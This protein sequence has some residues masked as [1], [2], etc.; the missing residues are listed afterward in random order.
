[1]LYGLRMP[2]P[3]PIGA[4]S[5]ITAAAPASSS[6][7][8]M[9]RVVVGVGQHVNPSRASVRVASS[10]PSMSGN[11]V[12]ESPMTSSLTRSPSPASRAR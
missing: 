5:G 6:C 3:E 8:A 4:P 1:M 10:R 12:R 7:L 9:H 2:S 11:S